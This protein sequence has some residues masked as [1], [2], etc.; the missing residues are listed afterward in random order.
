MR[1]ALWLAILHACLS[2]GLFGQDNRT[3]TLEQA[4]QLALHNH[5]RIGAAVMNAQA[6]GAAV[7]QVKAAYQPLLSGNLTTVGA[8]SGTSIAAGTLQTSGLSSRGAIGVGISQLVTDF[9]RTASLAESA[10]LRAASQDRNTATARAQVLVQVDQAYFSVLAAEAVLQVAQA[11]VEMQRLTLRQ[12]QA[13]AA[14]NLKSTPG[15]E[16]RGG[17]GLGGRA[18]IVSG[19]EHGKGESRAAQLRDRRGD[20]QPVHSRR[21][22][23]ARTGRKR[24]GEP[25]WGVAAESAGVVARQS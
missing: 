3:L 20:G 9:G 25:G 19:R 24:Y 4:E 1:L 18:G 23:A 15:C 22:A 12:V 2:A 10:R 13:L 21:C 11:Q 16:L 17:I 6:A 14:S 7:Q 5:P 8:D